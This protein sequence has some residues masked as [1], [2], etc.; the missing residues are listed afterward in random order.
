MT[1]HVSI[2]AFPAFCGAAVLSPEL[3]RAWLNPH[4]N[5][6]VVATQFI[7]LSGIPLVLYYCIDSALLAAKQSSVF[8]WM[9][10]LQA[11]TI[12]ATVLC[13][14]PFGLNL[15][16]LS[17]ALRAW[18]LLPV[19]LLWFRRACHVSVN[20]ALR[21]ALCSLVGA[22]I[23]AAVLSL[24]FLRP[25]WLSIRYD[26][27]FLIVTGA[28]VYAIYLRTFAREQLMAFLGEL[29]SRRWALPQHAPSTSNLRSTTSR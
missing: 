29:F 6:G 14:A 22:V 2:L 24:P 19:F 7:L 11:L 12:V 17:L 13:V 26:F 20:V 18:L 28:A 15:I 27:I 9:A 21:P 5:S 25:Q 1:Q 10:T 3:F 4:W 16:C 23:M 8:N